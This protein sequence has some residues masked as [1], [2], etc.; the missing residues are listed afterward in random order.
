[1]RDTGRADDRYHRL[2]RHP[3]DGRA[4][5]DEALRV[6]AVADRQWRFA[7]GD[8]LNAPAR[9]ALEDLILLRQPAKIG[10]ALVAPPGFEQAVEPLEIFRVVDDLPAFP[11]RLQQIVI[12]FWHVV[13]FHISF[14]VSQDESVEKAGRPVAVFIL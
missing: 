11:H 7:G 4:L 9:A 8:E 10:N 1:M 3:L 12:G 5:I 6:R 13:R 2:Q 14:V